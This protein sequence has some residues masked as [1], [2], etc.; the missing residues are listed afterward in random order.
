[1]GE[2][3]KFPRLP[4]LSQILELIPGQLIHAA[5]RK[6]KANRYYKTLSFRVH[7]VS[8]LFGVFSYCNGLRGCV[9]GCWHVKGSSPI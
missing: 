2:I 3:K 6:H 4:I 5:N 1:M 7:L 8:M 9:R